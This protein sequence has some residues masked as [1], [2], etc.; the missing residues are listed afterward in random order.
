MSG[1]LPFA[2]FVFLGIVIVLLI[3]SGLGVRARVLAVLTVGLA[4]FLNLSWAMADQF[5]GNGIDESIFFHLEMGMKGAAYGEFRNQFVLGALAIIAVGAVSVAVY[6]SISTKDEKRPKRA[7]G[8]AGLVLGFFVLLTNPGA[9]DLFRLAGSMSGSSLIVPEDFLVVHDLPRNQNPKNFVIL[10]AEQYERAFL[11]ES[12]FPGLSPNLNDL[13]DSSLSFTEIRQVSGTSWSIASMTAGFCGVPLVGAAMGNSMSGLD[14]FLPRANCIG[15]L[16]SSEGYRLE[17]VIGASLDFAGWGKLFENHGFASVRGVA[18]LRGEV[19]ADTQPSPWGLHD[20]YVLEI[21]AERITELSQAEQPFGFVVNTLDTHH[22]RGHAGPGCTDRPYGDG[23]DPLLDAIFCADRM[24]SEWVLELERSG[25]LENTVLIIASDHLAMPNTVWSTLEPLERR[26]LLLIRGDGIEARNDGTPGSPLDVGATLLDLI[27]YPVRGLGLGRSLVAEPDTGGSEIEDIETA[28]GDSA[29]Y[30][31]S[32]WAYPELGETIEIDKENGEIVLG[33]RTIR[34][35]ALFMLD[36][37]NM[38]KDIRFSFYGD[39]SLT[40]VVAGLSEPSRFLWVQDC[41]EIALGHYGVPAQDDSS[42]AL[43]GT[44]ESDLRW[45]TPLPQRSPIETEELLAPLAGESNGAN[46][47]A[48][49]PTADLQRAGQGSIQSKDAIVIRSASFGT[50]QSFVENRDLNQRVVLQRG[51]SVL[52]QSEVGR[53]D[54]LGHFDTCA[55]EAESGTLL[56]LDFHV[57]SYLSMLSTEYEW[58]FVVA[59]DSADCGRYSLAEVF[60]NTELRVGHDIG[61]RRPYIGLVGRTGKVL[62]L[63]GRPETSIELDTASLVDDRPEEHG[64]TGAP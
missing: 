40:E 42:C 5:T 27:G 25:A 53:I 32:L 57:E 11:D 17:H 7:R 10:Y 37:Q 35:P 55:F 47:R 59:H 30:I 4:L 14:H 18:A 21:A 19:P 46:Y 43:L 62:E 36:P 23:S 15:D 50:G 8:M 34:Y 1:L 16:L 61:F 22:P 39:K 41:E 9:L 29:S 33:S 2:N 44:D 31:A 48:V 12:V 60:A 51:I 56:A 3:R 24:I 38:V 52:G 20:E 26:N 54:L 28:I 49:L 64:E 58:L 45:A 13:E 6:K 63:T